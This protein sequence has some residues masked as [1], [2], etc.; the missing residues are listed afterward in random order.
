MVPLTHSSDGFLKCN[1]YFIKSLINA[2]W[3]DSASKVFIS[4][5]ES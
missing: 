1:L 2:L 4:G 3:K 5:H